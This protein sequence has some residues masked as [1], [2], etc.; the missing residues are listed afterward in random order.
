[1]QPQTTLDYDRISRAIRYI[2]NNYQQQPTLAQIAQEVHLSEF[3]FERMFSRW[4]GTTPQRFMRY[5]TKEHA[6]QLLDESQGL[7]EVAEAT[8]LSGTSR[9]HDLFVTYEAMTPG[10]YKQKGLGLTIMYGFH[11]TPFGQE[12][13]SY[14]LIQTIRAY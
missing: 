12:F 2:E 8:G 5:L 14:V 7:S 4:A 3:H 13:W 9:L 11:Q 1:M 10:E 6:R